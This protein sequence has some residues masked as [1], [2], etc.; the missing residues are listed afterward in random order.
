MTPP[1]FFV[2]VLGSLSLSPSRSHS[3]TGS[4]QGKEGIKKPPPHKGGATGNVLLPPIQ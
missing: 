2:P 3:P 4:N 1:V